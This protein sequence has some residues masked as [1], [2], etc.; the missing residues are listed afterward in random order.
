MIIHYEMTL[1]HLLKN[2]YACIKKLH[3]EDGR[4]T[5]RNLLTYCK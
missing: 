4:I 5:G 3:P 1:T 2:A